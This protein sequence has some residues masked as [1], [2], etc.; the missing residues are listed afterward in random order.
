METCIHIANLIFLAS[1][2]VRDVACLRA[3]TMVAL[4]LLTIYFMQVG[5]LWAAVFWNVLFI[6]INGLQL[7]RLLAQSPAPSSREV[8][9]DIHSSMPFGPSMARLP[10]RV[11]L[12]D[13]L[14]DAAIRESW[15]HPL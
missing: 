11:D 12:V 6:G 15:L 10:H 14:R 4:A 8:A 5:P 1:Y 13:F 3:L 7:R 9:P 2:L